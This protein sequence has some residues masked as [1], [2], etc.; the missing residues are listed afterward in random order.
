[1]F[2]KGPTCGK[3]WGASQNCLS[4]SPR[5]GRGVSGD[6]NVQPRARTRLSFNLVNPL[7]NS[8]PGGQPSILGHGPLLWVHVGLLSLSQHPIHISSAKLTDRRSEELTHPRHLRVSICVFRKCALRILNASLS[9]KDHL[10]LGLVLSPHRCYG[11]TGYP[12]EEVKSII[13][14]NLPHLCN[15]PLAYLCGKQVSTLPRAALAQLGACEKMLCC[16]L[17]VPEESPQ[18]SP[19]GTQAP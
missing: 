1:M 16:S 12:Q 5:A 14:I 15:G 13:N 4:S 10:Q 19:A 7:I 6:I 2:N 8:L 11:C 18:G 9:R 3:T 17:S